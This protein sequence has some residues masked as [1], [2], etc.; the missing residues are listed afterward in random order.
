MEGS[1]SQLQYTDSFDLFVFD[2][3]GT[4]AE[5]REDLAASLNFA[6]ERLGY[7]GRDR[8]TV[9]RLTGNGAT[10]FMERALGSAATKELVE[11]GVRIFLEHYQNHC[12]VRTALYPGVKDTVVS[13]CKAG[14][15]LAVLTN[16]PTAMSL[17]ILEGLGIAGQFER[18]HGG[19]SFPIRKPD[20]LG[21]R[22]IMKSFEIPPERTLMVGDSSVDV[23]TARAAGVAVAGVV[24]GFKPDEF[25][26]YPPDYILENVQDLLGPASRFR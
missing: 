7:P 3:D 5:T 19:D 23:E 15:R 26:E 14:K 12:L 4:L 13:L 25:A 11:E 10:V 18:I 6:L 9:G 20:P 1:P 24:W 16:K 8:E 2:L 17:K 22:Q 21:L